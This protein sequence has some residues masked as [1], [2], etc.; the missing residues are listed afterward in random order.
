MHITPHTGR[1]HAVRIATC[2]VVSVYSTLTGSSGVEASVHDR[3]PKP[4]SVPTAVSRVKVVTAVPFAPKRE[5]AKPAKV[6]VRDAIQP[7]KS[8]TEV[9]ILM[10]ETPEVKARSTRRSVDVLLDRP[11]RPSSNKIHP[12]QPRLT[13]GYKAATRYILDLKDET[14]QCVC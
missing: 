4:D 5:S 11:H 12:S 3:L 10:N 6:V 14:F 13:L 7:L 9:P 1:R 8:A 2:L